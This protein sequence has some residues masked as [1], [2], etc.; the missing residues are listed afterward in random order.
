MTRVDR[1]P[2][3]DLADCKV[4]GMKLDEIAAEYNVSVPTVKRWM[5]YYGLTER[6]RNK[7]ELPKSLIAI[8]PREDEHLCLLDR[9]KRILGDRWSMQKQRG[10]FLDGR[11]VK[12]DDLIRAAGL[13]PRP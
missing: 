10:Y 13:S 2:R 4:E 11:A 5:S 3:E 12:A 8:G 9:A 6:R 1:P 7:D